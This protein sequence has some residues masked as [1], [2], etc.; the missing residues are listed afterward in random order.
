MNPSIDDQNLDEPHFDE[1]ATI[2]AAR[3]VVPLEEV[4]SAKRS[5]GALAVV[6]AVGG[7]LIIGLL[8]A[9][10]MFRYFSVS[11]PP[12]EETTSATEQPANQLPPISS[13]VE[14]N[15]DDVATVTTEVE[16]IPV[17]SEE[18]VAP[19]APAPER[20]PQVEPR[21]RV[22]VNEPRVSEEDEEE[23]QREIRRAERQEERRERRRAARKQQRAE[24][25]GNDDLSR[26]R[27]IFEGTPRP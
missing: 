10:L 17:E 18:T 21:P 8:A 4:R 15:T 27:E 11:Q 20:K 23:R 19:R 25:D 22:I 7:G 24:A 5:K 12:V 14:A 16:Q 3:P 2:L 13:G 9:T 1:E 6:L 26:I